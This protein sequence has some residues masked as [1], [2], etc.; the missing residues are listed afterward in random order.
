MKIDIFSWDLGFGVWGF[1]DKDRSVAVA[2][3]R[4]ARKQRIFFGDV[5]V[6]VNGNRRDMQFA[7]KCALTEAER[8]TFLAVGPK[9]NGPPRDLILVPAEGVRGRFVPAPHRA[10][11]I[12]GDD[13]QR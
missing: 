11:R 12:E 3:A 5:S 9:G 10:L 2:H 13:R 7:A 1:P 4:T 8:L 6:G